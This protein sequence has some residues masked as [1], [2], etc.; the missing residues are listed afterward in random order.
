LKR[1][2]PENYIKGDGMIKHTHEQIKNTVGADLYRDLKTCYLTQNIHDDTLARILSKGN[3]S[4]ELIDSVKEDQRKAAVRF[5]E[6]LSAFKKKLNDN[7]MHEEVEIQEA[8]AMVLPPKKEKE[9]IIP[10]PFDRMA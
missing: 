9:I 6:L 10:G 8:I 3:G 4:Q 5:T 1:S 7:G 2:R